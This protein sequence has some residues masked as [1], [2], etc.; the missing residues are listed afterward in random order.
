MIQLLFI[1]LLSLFCAIPS[2]QSMDS[3]SQSMDVEEQEG[4][5]L[6]DLNL[7]DLFLKY[8]DDQDI[9]E[10]ELPCFDGI[11]IKEISNRTPLMLEVEGRNLRKGTIAVSPYIIRPEQ[12]IGFPFQL[13]KLTSTNM[14][15][16]VLHIDRNNTEIFCE[17]DDK[18]TTLYVTKPLLNGNLQTEVYNLKGTIKSALKAKRLQ[19]NSRFTLEADIV[20]EPNPYGFQDDIKIVHPRLYIENK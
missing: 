8:Q 3:D 6:I 13:T 7:E 20:V 14:T 12:A 1:I 16:T 5:S 2:L 19:K 10:D 4:M 11:I 17:S 18:P 15:E 9:P